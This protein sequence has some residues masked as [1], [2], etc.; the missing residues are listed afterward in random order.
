MHG[1]RG[2]PA[3]LARTLCRLPRPL[4]G[5]GAAHRHNDAGALA[6]QMARFI[7]LEILMFRIRQE[8]D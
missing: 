5:A 2:A 7:G 1:N 4:R 3:L 6:A 8:L